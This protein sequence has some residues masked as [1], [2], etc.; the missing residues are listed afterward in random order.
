MKFSNCVLEGIQ[1][2]CKIST[3]KPDQYEVFSSVLTLLD[4]GFPHFLPFNPVL[5]FLYP[6]L[7]R[8]LNCAIIPT[9]QRST[10]MFTFVTWPLFQ[11]SFYPSVINL[12]SGYV[13]CPG[14]KHIKSLRAN[15]I[16]FTPVLTRRVLSIQYITFSWTRLNN[17]IEQCC[18]LIQF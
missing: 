13:P 5:R 3:R 15:A 4:V 9:S 17:Q 16:Y 11:H 2:L 6:F 18:V 14:P 12:F 1:L 10:N 7:T 8:N